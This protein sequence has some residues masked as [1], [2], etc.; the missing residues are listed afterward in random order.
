MFIHLSEVTVTITQNGIYF[1]TLE[2]HAA[3]LSR[4]KKPQRIILLPSKF[5][6]VNKGEPTLVAY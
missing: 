3:V 1:V 5:L 6:E 2:F 4:R